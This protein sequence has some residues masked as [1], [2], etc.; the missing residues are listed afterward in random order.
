MNERKIPVDGQDAS[1]LNAMIIQRV[2][3]V[4][5]VGKSCAV[6]STYIKK[7]LD[8]SCINAGTRDDY[9]TKRRVNG[10]SWW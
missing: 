6:V 7:K 3:M 8:T 4:S 2:Q 10:E 9:L 5:Y 1:L